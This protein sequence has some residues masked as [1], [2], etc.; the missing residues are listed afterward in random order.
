MPALSRLAETAQSL[1]RSPLLSPINNVLAI[2]D[3]LAQFNPL[4][5]LS[6]VK[7]RIVAIRQETPDTRTLVLRPNVLWQGHEPGQ[8]V[9][10]EIEIEGRRLQRTY[11]VASIDDGSGTLEITVKRQRRGKVSQWLNSEAQVGDLLTLS[12][13]AGQFTLPSPIPQKLLMLSAGSGITPVMSMLRALDAQ[14]YDG[15]VLFLHQC[16]SPEDLIFGVELQEI[17]ARMRG[18]SLHVRYSAESGRLSM[19]M[20][21]AIVPDYAARRAFLCG[22]Q[23]FM[24]EVRAFYRERRLDGQLRLESFSGPIVRGAPVAGAAVEVRCAKSEQL[25]T[26]SGAQPL[27]LEAESAGLRPKH[28]CRIGICQSCKC[29]KREGTVQ[30]LITGE[31][32]SEPNEMIQLCVSVARSDLTLDL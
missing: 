1:L 27:L 25:F 20:L 28:G 9:S 19:D 8:H 13:A 12:R 24:D 26:T 14:G 10:V 21:Q 3:L 15:D 5:S 22:P 32:S 23:G 29:R 4:W 31:V 2:D 6:Q 7:A 30:N 11:T 18:L 17:A 16:R